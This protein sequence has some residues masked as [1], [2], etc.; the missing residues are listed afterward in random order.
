MKKEEEKTVKW[1]ELNWTPQKNK[2]SVNLC[3]CFTCLLFGVVGGG[4]LEHS[5][6]LQ[7]KKKKKKQEIICDVNC[8]IVFRFNFMGAKKDKTD[9][10][11]SRDLSRGIFESYDIFVLQK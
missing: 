5:S 10:V 8:K 4:A 1:I 2:N 11:F 9:F 6:K 7:N 3:G